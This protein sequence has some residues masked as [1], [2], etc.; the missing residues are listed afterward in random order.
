M[1]LAQ[2]AAAPE[3]GARAVR[4]LLDPGK[5]ARGDIGGAELVSPANQTAELEVL[6]AHHARIRSATGLI[7]VREVPDDL[8]L[9]FCC[10]VDE[11]VGNPKLMTNGAGVGDGLRPATLIFG[12]GN[13]ILGP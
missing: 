3:Q 7:L 12:A 2:V 4:A 1:V 9:K 13:T 6:V 8:L 10:L 5:M 11:I